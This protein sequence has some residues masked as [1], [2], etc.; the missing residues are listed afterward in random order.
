M[1]HTGSGGH[2][3]DLTGAHLRSVPHAVL[4]LHD[5][6]V[7]V[8]DDLHVLVSVRSEPLA[9]L[10]PVLVD[11]P[12]GAEVHEVRIVV[13]GKREREVRVEPAVVGVPALVRSSDL[14]H[15]VA[16][17]LIGSPMRRKP[18]GKP[19]LARNRPGGV[20]KHAL[21]PPEGGG[22]AGPRGRLEDAR[23]AR[24]G[25][26]DRTRASATGGIWQ[27][28]PVGFDLQTPLVRPPGD[29]GFP[30]AAPR[31]GIRISERAGAPFL[32]LQ[33]ASAAP[34]QANS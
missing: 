19:Y 28:P 4:V 11:H 13:V 16:P 3:L 17:C 34:G 2:D 10:H 24:S 32:G 33:G 30:L 5:A 20:D 27:H 29:R 6:F 8:G 1:H 23:S 31:Y 26:K 9:G 15:R 22:R 14:D 12:Q 25:G 7:D 21:S 18:T